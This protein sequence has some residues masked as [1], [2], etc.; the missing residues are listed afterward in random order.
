M[1]SKPMVPKPGPQGKTIPAIHIAGYL[2][3]V[4]SANEKLEGQGQQENKHG[5]GP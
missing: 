3:Q 5:S 2:D 4:C 1:S